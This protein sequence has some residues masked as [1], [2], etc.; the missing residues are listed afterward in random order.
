M[1]EFYYIGAGPMECAN[2]AQSTGVF[3]SDH[4][5][6]LPILAPRCIDHSW[7]DRGGPQPQIY[8]WVFNS[9]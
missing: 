1:R 5:D 9:S 2:A 3:F 8:G 7:S 6:L 4:V